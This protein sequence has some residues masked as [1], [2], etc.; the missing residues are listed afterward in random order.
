MDMCRY[1]GY[2]FPPVYSLEEGI[3]IREFRFSIGDRLSKNWDW[4]LARLRKGAIF[5]V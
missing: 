2:G 5:V 4:L 1:E 3:G